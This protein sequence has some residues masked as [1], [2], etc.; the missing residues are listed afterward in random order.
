MP[1]QADVQAK[2]KAL[3]SSGFTVVHSPKIRPSLKTELEKQA[4]AAFTRDQAS[5]SCTADG[6]SS[7]HAYLMQQV[8]TGNSRGEQE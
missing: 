7:T 6:A 3:A 2:S 4:S 8:W 5:M 1:S